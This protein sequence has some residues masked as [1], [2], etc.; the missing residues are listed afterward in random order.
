MKTPEAPLTAAERIE[1]AQSWLTSAGQSIAPWHTA[2]QLEGRAAGHAG[3]AERLARHAMAEDQP[4]VRLVFLELA[5][6]QAIEARACLAAA[7]A[8]RQ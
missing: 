3:V 1:R 2:E 8:A 7:V 6:L 5:G 4:N